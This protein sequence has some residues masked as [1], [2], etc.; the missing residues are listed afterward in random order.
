MGFG[1]D[2]VTVH[3]FSDNERVVLSKLSWRQLDGIFFEV[4]VFLTC[5][6]GNMVTCATLSPR[7]TKWC[8]PLMVATPVPTTLEATRGKFQ[9]LGSD[10][11]VCWHSA[12]DAVDVHAMNF[13]VVSGTHVTVCVCCLQGTLPVEPLSPAAPVLPVHKE[14][15]D[16][17]GSGPRAAVSGQG[18]WGE[19]RG[20]AECEGGWGLCEVRGAL[21]LSFV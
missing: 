12:V 19:E 17:E 1:T 20:G 14:L 2:G 9:L 13:R 11:G 3:S 15:P 7:I 18:R 8:F 16:Q 6:H 10:G 4:H 21:T 5:S